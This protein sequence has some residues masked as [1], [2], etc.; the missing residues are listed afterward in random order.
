MTKDRKVE[1]IID[2]IASLNGAFSDPESQA[3]RLRNPLL[4][5]SFARPGK[6]EADSTGHRI[7]NSMLAGYR[8]SVF[9]LEK[10]LSG[11][12]RAGL[13]QTDKLENLLGVYELRPGA[14]YDQIVA[15]L[16]MALEDPKIAKSTPLS[17]FLTDDET[18]EE[19]I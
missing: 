4:L 6:H 16:R 2:A 1:S 11:Q 19:R 13:K 8:A 5:R 12:S 7:F 14:G 15:F 3:Y 9:D 10:K 17:Y 18:D